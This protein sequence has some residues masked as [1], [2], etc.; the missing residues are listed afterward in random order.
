MKRKKTTLIS[1]FSLSLGCFLSLFHEA[2][3]AEALQAASVKADVSKKD[4]IAPQNKELHDKEQKERAA[5]L[6][7]SLQVSK[8]YLDGID[9]GDYANSWTVTDPIFQHTITKDGWAKALQIGRQPLGKV[10][11]RTLGDQ[12]IAMNPHGLPAG[13]YMVIVYNTSFEKA[14]E[15]SE[16]VT[17]HRGEDGKWRPLT[18]EIQ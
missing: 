15:L 16:L 1:L 2:E 17:L 3:A 12:R 6:I 18:Y 14:P 4:D 10:K 11:S 7:E 5:W 9:R 8:E 13:A